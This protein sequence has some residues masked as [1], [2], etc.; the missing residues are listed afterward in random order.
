[1]NRPYIR[2]PVCGKLARAYALGHAGIHRLEVRRVLHGSSPG[3]RGGFT[4]SQEPMP[5]DLLRALRAGLVK[6]LA[7]IDSMITATIV[8]LRPIGQRV[9]I[10]DRQSTGVLGTSS[11]PSLLVKESAH[12]GGSE[13]QRVGLRVRVGVL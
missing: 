3:H 5:L 13:G 10:A 8:V 11:N 7:Q 1:M 9:R 4:W 2:C 12:V 6:A